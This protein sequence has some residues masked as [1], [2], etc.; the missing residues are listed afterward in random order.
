[1]DFKILAITGV[2]VFIDSHHVFKSSDMQWIKTTA[3]SLHHAFCFCRPLRENN[4][5]RRYVN[6]HAHVHTLD[7]YFNI[8]SVPKTRYI[9]LS[10][11]W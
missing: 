7:D 4:I 2:D 5:K 11:H 1:M 3:K 6:I 8:N 10:V 9:C